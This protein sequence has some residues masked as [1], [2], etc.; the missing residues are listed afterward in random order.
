MKSK[1]CYY[2]IRKYVVARDKI[3]KRLEQ[4]G[5]IDQYES[6]LV[7]RLNFAIYTLAIQL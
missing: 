5:L 1:T 2:S 3:I 6:S 4:S 7:H